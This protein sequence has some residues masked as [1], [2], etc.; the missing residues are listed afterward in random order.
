ML[1]VHLFAVSDTRKC[2]FLLSI[3]LFTLQTQHLFPLPSPSPRPL[4][5]PHP[6]I[7]DHLVPHT[8]IQQH[9]LAISNKL[10]IPG[11]MSKGELILKRKQICLETCS[12]IF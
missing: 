3:P 6:P 9:D 5:L 2:H 12:F 8:H 10:N 7:S 4:S 11:F 1:V